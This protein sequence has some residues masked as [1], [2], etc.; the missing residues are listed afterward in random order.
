MAT[1]SRRRCTRSCRRF[2]S[3]CCTSTRRCRSSWCAIVERALAKPR[4]ERYQHMSEMLRDLAVYRQQLAGTDSPGGRPCSRRPTA[5][6]LP[7]GTFQVTPPIPLPSVAT[8][9]PAHR[10]ANADAAA[11]GPSPS[12][13]PAPSGVPIVCC[14]QPSRCSRSPSPPRRCGCRHIRL[15]SAVLTPA[16]VATPRAARTIDRRL[17]ADRAERVRGGRLRH[18]RAH[19][20][21]RAR[22][23]SRQR[24]R[25]AAPRS[26]T[27]RGDLPW[28][29]A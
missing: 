5:P 18:G 25:A 20:R 9:L 19:C 2:R 21:T 29:R 1:R 8:P 10:C 13:A 17:D 27:C 4:D 16:S 7:I 22:A 24:G 12:S 23:G 15:R 3:R 28:K 14:C 6:R 11:S 26:R